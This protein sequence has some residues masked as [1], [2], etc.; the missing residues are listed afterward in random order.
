MVKTYQWLGYLVRR[1]CCV[2]RVAFMALRVNYGSRQDP[3][4]ILVA[5]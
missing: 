3:D 5:R 4:A 2:Q 1:C